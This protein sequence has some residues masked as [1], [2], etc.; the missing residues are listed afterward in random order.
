MF[1]KT[2]YFLKQHALREPLHKPGFWTCPFTFNL[3]LLMPINKSLNPGKNKRQHPWQIYLNVILKES[4]YIGE[5][6]ATTKAFEKIIGAKKK[7]GLLLLDSEA[8]L[9]STASG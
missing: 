3:D 6:V 5:M 2:K 4:G 9:L 8:E 7:I 1:N